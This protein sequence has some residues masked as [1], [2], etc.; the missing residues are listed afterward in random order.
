[1]EYIVNFLSNEIN[2]F[3]LHERIVRCRDC[4]HAEESESGAL[5]CNGYLVELWDWYNDI[6]NNGVKVEPDDFCAWGERKK[7]RIEQ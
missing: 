4:E 3:V 5:F 2:D 1:M 6:P 7:E